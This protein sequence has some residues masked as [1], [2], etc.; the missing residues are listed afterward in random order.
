MEI[1]SLLAIL[2]LFSMIVSIVTENISSLMKPFVNISK[3]KLW[4]ALAWTGFGVVGLNIGM[5]ESLD[6]ITD[7]ARDWIHYFDL[8]LTV[9]FFTTGAQ[10]VH[11]LWDMWKE[12]NGR[13]EEAK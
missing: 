1:I 6:M 8:A 11:K 12:Y 4:I 3:Y 10:G 9:T 2:A 5:L 7:V 13:K